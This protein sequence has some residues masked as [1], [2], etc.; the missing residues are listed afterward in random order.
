MMKVIS[1]FGASVVGLR[2]SGGG[3]NFV[4]SFGK[5]DR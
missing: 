2:I 4:T 1:G 3:R 5:Y